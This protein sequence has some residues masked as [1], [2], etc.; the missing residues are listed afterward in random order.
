MSELFTEEEIENRMPYI[1]RHF[2]KRLKF[3]IFFK[4]FKV[5]KFANLLGCGRDTLYKYFRSEVFPTNQS[6]E[7]ILKLLDV[8]VSAFAS[9]VFS[10]DNKLYRWRD[11]D[12][13][14]VELIEF[15]LKNLNDFLAHKESVMMK[16]DRICRNVE[17]YINEPTFVYS[18]DDLLDPVDAFLNKFE[19]EYERNHQKK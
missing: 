14:L 16:I 11:G 9:S 2:G 8:D 3:L 15:D 10:M 18:L 7:N 1:R 19:C 4:G 5:T 17:R 13:N 6:F 12:D